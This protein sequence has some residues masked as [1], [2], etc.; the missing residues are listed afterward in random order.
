MTLQERN[1]QKRERIEKYVL[2][3]SYIAAN[4]GYE[5]LRGKLDNALLLVQ[6]LG[7]SGAVMTLDERTIQTLRQLETG[8]RDARR[9]AAENGCDELYGKLDHAFV[10]VQNLG[11]G[12]QIVSDRAT[13]AT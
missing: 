9:D 10:W 4:N 8:L 11:M 5:E 13:F 2:D 1:T 3:A 12:L 6:D 7:A